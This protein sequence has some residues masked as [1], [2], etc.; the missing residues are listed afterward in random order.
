[1]SLLHAHAPDPTPE[2]LAQQYVP[3]HSLCGLPPAE[4]PAQSHWQKD[5][6][7]SQYRAPQMHTFSLGSEQQR[8]PLPRSTELG[9]HTSDPVMFEPH[10]HAPAPNDRH[11]FDCAPVPASPPSAPEWLAPLQAAS[12]RTHQIPKR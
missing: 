4:T 5:E 6:N 3:V 2:L 1:L 12:K 8:A 11:P 7:W 9:L 10:S